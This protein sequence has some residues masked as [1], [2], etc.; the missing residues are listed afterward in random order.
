MANKPVLAANWKMNPTTA[1]EAAELLQGITEA[2]RGQDRVQRPHRRLVRRQ[3]E[4]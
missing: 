4:M 1:G 2:A 3:F